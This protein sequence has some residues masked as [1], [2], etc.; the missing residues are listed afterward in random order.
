[1]SDL[2]KDYNNSKVIKVINESM[3]MNV[4]QNIDYIKGKKKRDLLD[5][6]SEEELI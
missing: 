5:G 4:M 1:M 6:D 2:I 3:Q